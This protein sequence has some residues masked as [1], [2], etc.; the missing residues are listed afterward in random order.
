MLQNSPTNTV[1]QSPTSHTYHISCHLS[2]CNIL[3][4][5]YLLTYLFN[6]YIYICIH[7]QYLYSVSSIF[8]LMSAVMPILMLVSL[9]KTQKV[10]FCKMQF[11]FTTTIAGEAFAKEMTFCENC[12]NVSEIFMVV[13]LVATKPGQKQ[14][15][16]ST[17]DTE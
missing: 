8:L 10:N 1:T 3:T 16:M 7:K 6:I 9:G 13:L 5:T 14:L 17:K 12:Q 2:I 15:K 4:L 11:Q